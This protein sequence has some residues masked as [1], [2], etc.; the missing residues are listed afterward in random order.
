MAATSAASRHRSRANRAEK[1]D[2][3]PPVVVVT[4]VVVV[5][6]VMMVVM[7][8]P[9]PPATVVM[10]VM[11]P[12]MMMVISHERH[13]GVAISGQPTLGRLIRIERAQQRSRIGNRIEQFRV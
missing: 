4:M 13:V 10:V 8:V 9:P 6:A 11:T 3:S 7:V 1:A 5:P 2:S 12:T